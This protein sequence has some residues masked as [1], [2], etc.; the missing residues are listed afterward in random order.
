[1][2]HG[3]MGHILHLV[4]MLVILLGPSIGWTWT[5]ILSAGVAAFAYWHWHRS[6]SGHAEVEPAETAPGERGE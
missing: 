5:L 6:R 3:G 2:G 1:M 4:P